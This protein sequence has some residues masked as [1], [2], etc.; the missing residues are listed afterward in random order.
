MNKIE[1]MKLVKESKLDKYEKLLLLDFI[2]NEPESS[3]PFV[4]KEFG[5]KSITGSLKKAKDTVKSGYQ[6]AT[7]GNPEFMKNLF[8]A[9]SEFTAGYGPGNAIGD[10]VAPPALAYAKKRGI[11]K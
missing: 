3:I 1:A 2:V 11:L 10:L 7:Y 6:K 8:K 4:L 5:L 9:G